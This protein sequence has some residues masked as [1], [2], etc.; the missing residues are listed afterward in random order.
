MFDI[1]AAKKRCDA[2]T[3]GDWRMLSP[4]CLFVDRQPLL[5]HYPRAYY[6]GSTKHS[7]PSLSTQA[8]K[9]NAEFIAHARTDLPAALEALEEAQRANKVLKAQMRI[10]SVAID[11]AGVW[12]ER[13]LQAERE[14]DE[15]QGKLD[16][17]TDNLRGFSEILAV[18][19]THGTLKLGFGPDWPA[20]KVQ[21]AIDRILRGSKE[22][23]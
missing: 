4:G 20:K 22:E 10:A 14:R 7:L 15:A 17:L 9:A 23:E 21:L 6:S 19:V 12:Q 2:A 8:R 11:G 13:A 1:A 18:E 16:T 5:L 3:Q